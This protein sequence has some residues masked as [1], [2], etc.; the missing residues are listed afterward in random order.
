MVIGGIKLDSELRFLL[1]ISSTRRDPSSCVRVCVCVCECVCVCVSVCGRCVQC[2]LSPTECMHDLWRR[3]VRWRYFINLTGRE[4][5]LKTNLE[6]VRI[7]TTYNGS[8]DIDGTL[9]K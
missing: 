7:L 9:H 4:F 6:L 2:L 1:S 3:S 5:P 8:N